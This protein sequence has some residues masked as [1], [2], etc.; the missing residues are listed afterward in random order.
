MVVDNVSGKKSRRLC[1]RRNE[2]PCK[3]IAEPMMAK[4][5]AFS[6]EKPEDSLGFLLWKTT[7]SWQRLIKAALAEYEVSHAQF[8]IMA[9]MRWFS[10][11]KQEPTQ[12]SIAHHSG[13]DKMTISKSLKKLAAMG[14]VSR[15]EDTRDTRAKIVVLTVKGNKLI[16]KLVAIVDDID[17]KFFGVLNKSEQNNLGHIFNCLVEKHNK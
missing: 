6:V 10:E 11:T 1:A 13:L 8:V 14:I 12:I 7:T 3:F 17:K 4:K 16:E 15:A 5:S 9:T 2:F